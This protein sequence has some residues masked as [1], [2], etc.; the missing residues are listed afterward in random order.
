MTNQETDTA[1]ILE[2]ELQRRVKQVL[3]GVVHD[4]V[5][6]VMEK[7][8]AMQKEAMLM[9]VSLSVGK[10]FKVIE[11]EGRKPLWEATPEEFGLTK[12]DLATHAL[13]RKENSENPRLDSA[14]GI[15]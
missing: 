11:E 9:E 10:M 7:Q 6:Q 15:I 14:I 3:A 1:L 2:N 8:F 4:V 13:G 5:K 12:E